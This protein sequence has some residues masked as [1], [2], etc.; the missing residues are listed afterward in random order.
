MPTD[1]LAK[2]EKRLGERS[3]PPAR[4]EVSLL[5]RL[6]GSLSAYH[7]RRTRKHRQSAPEQTFHL[8]R[9][10]KG[11]A[12][13]RFHRTKGFWRTVGDGDFLEAVRRDGVGVSILQ[14]ESQ[15]Q[16]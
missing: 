15:Q 4:G 9:K 8:G 3:I 5:S 16:S 13:A 7:T 12:R 11:S 2:W 1:W 10:N 6:N 14:D